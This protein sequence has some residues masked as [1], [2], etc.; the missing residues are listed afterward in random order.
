MIN[1]DFVTLAEVERLTGLAFKTI[2]RRI[3]D[4]KPEI[5]E[6]ASHFYSLRKL[7]PLIISREKNDALD[8][9]N[10]RAKLAAAQTEKTELVVAQMKAKLVPV[11]DIEEILTK[12]FTSIRAKILAL[13]SR[14][15]AQKPSQAEIYHVMRDEIHAI[16]TEPTT[17]DPALYTPK[18]F[19][20]GVS[21]ESD[22]IHTSSEIH[23]LDLG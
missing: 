17:L 9:S 7:V 14:L 3:G 19:I 5:K 16:L 10:E 20:A 15:E 22:G 11:E 6:G 4:V 13:P 2:K 12:L 1:P 23:G 8:L 18:R 21:E